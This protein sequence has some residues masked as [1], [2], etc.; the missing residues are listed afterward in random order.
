MLT[1][2][3]ELALVFSLPLQ[4]LLTSALLSVL[5]RNTSILKYTRPCILRNPFAQKEYGY[6]NQYDQSRND[7]ASKDI[8]GDGTEQRMRNDTLKIGRVSN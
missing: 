4:F 8:G 7:L 2:V 6:K 3:L 1:H 5:F